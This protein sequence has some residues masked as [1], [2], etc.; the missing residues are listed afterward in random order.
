MTLGGQEFLTCGLVPG[1][2]LSVRSVPAACLERHWLLWNRC[3][4][5]AAATGSCGMP[6]TS[7]F[8]LSSGRPSAEGQRGAGR[9]AWDRRNLQIRRHRSGR[10]RG[11]GTPG[12][13][14]LLS[15]TG[16]LGNLV[17]GNLR[18]EIWSVVRGQRRSASLL[19]GPSLT[20]RC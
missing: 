6:A 7:R 14:D 13:V 5:A 15:S 8:H 20:L 16:L 9:K 11:A 3:R 10:R 2:T 12:R 18:M 17:K 1:I 19:S 4:A